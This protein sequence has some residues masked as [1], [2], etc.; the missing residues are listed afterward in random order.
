[1]YRLRALHRSAA[2]A[3]LCRECWPQRCDQAIHG[4]HSGGHQQNPL[5]QGDQRSC[6][7]PP[8]PSLCPSFSQ[9]GDGA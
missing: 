6:G 3:A 8:R 4:L 1:M 5:Q 2:P 7:R 9:R